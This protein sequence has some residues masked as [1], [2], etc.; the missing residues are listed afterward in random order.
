MNRKKKSQNSNLSPSA[1]KQQAVW[2]AVLYRLMLAG[3]LGV[4][5]KDW[6]LVLS[7]KIVRNYG[8]GGEVVESQD[9]ELESTCCKEK[10]QMTVPGVSRRTDRQRQPL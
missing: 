6:K 3:G 4:E 1:N 8:K 5:Q 10:S 7:P 9:Y 2:C